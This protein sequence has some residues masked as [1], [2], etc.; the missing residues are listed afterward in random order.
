VPKPL[1]GFLSLDD[2]AE[3]RGELAL[4]LEYDSKTQDLSITACAPLPPDTQEEDVAAAYV[5]LC[6]TDAPPLY[7]FFFSDSDTIDQSTPKP[8]L[9]APV[10]TFL[11]A[12]PP[13][14]VYAG[15]KYKPVALKVRPVETELPS[16]FWITRNIIGDP[17]KNMPA[18]SL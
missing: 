12:R 2:L 15:K 18:L 14:A 9:K 11:D 16:R 8:Q 1:P 4:S 13:L 5:S 6:N 10:Y 3:G 17:L 7:N